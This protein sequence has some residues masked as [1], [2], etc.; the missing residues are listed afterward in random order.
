[1]ESSAPVVIVAPTQRCGSSLLQRLLNSTGKIIVYGENFYLLQ[2]LPNMLLELHQNAEERTKI[3]SN[4]LD[5]FLNTD[6]DF[7]ASSL[8]PDYIDYLQS[9][10]AGFHNIIS[11]YGAHAKEHGFERWG[12]KH[13]IR[14][15]DGFRFVLGLLP[16]ARYIF[17]YRDLLD[18]ARSA[19]SRW[20]KRFSQ[21]DEYRRLGQLWQK[22][23]RSILD[24]RGD[25]FL[26][27]R[28]ETLIADPEHHLDLLEDFVD[29]R[30]INRDVVNIKINRHPVLSETNIKKAKNVYREPENMIDQETVALFADCS[31]FYNERG[32]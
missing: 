2:N 18:V 1:M 30:G 13:Q 16:H 6:F 11:Y 3:V 27:F 28:Y 19:K 20:P 25:N 5:L 22:N 7:E 26:T 15:Y 12:I 8:F 4:T 17:I 24:L 31:D 23:L 32:Y 10:R 14:Q 29:I 9:T 21:L